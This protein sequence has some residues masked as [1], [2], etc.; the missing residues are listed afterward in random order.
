[1]PVILQN[2]ERVSKPVS[3]RGKDSPKF[4]DHIKPMLAKLHKEP[5]NNPGWIYEIKWDGYRAIAEVNK[6]EI[7]LYSRNGLSFKEYYVVV[8]EELKKIKKD[9]IIDGEIVALDKKGKPSFQLLQQY[10]Q[11]QTPICYYVFDCLYINGRSI[12][13]KPLLER[14]KLLK[15]L[16]PK[17][18]I[19]RYCDHVEENGKDFFRALQK[20]GRGRNDSKKGRWGLP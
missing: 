9:T 7:R 20:K 11:E 4:K 13:D 17:S 5:F 18:D 19:I 15:E 2:P 6:K 1:M 16:L 10:I 8:Y 14:K 3:L 12:E